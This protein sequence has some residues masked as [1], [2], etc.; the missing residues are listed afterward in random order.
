MTRISASQP[1]IQ[2]EKREK[3]KYTK[4]AAK[5][6]KNASDSASDHST[7]GVMTSELS[8]SKLKISKKPVLTQSTPARKI[9]WYASIPSLEEL[10]KRAQE[11]IVAKSQNVNTKPFVENISGRELVCLPFVDVGIPD[12]VEYNYPAEENPKI[13]C[14]YPRAARYAL[15]GI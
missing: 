5:F 3:R 4:R 12:V 6:F 13:E 9:D 11:K 10:Q 14:P 8:L 2:E 7:N 15:K 1:I